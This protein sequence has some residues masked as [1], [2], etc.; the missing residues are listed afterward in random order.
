MGSCHAK[1]AG[2]SDD[3]DEKTDSAG[4]AGGSG[5]KL[6]EFVS[7]REVG[8]ISLLLGARVWSPWGPQFAPSARRGNR[9]QTV[10]R[11]HGV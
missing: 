8:H 6:T 3:H 4:Y 1:Q 11:P 7:A 2:A 5:M 9:R 10:L